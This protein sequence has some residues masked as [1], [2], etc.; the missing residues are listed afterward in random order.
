MRVESGARKLSG[1]D[2]VMVNLQIAKE[3][4]KQKLKADGFNADVS[5]IQRGRGVEYIVGLIK[6][7]GT[8]RQVRT[9][10]CSIGAAIKALE[11]LHFD[12]VNKREYYI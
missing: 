1:I 7:D 5:L 10:A 3:S 9:G 12:I 8:P 6:R 2:A 11:S 4:L